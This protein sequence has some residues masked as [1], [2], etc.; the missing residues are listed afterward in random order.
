MSELIDVFESGDVVLTRDFR[1]QIY[2][3]SVSDDGWLNLKQAP[4]VS[5]IKSGKKPHD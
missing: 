3:W 2:V 1:G 4:L 5:D